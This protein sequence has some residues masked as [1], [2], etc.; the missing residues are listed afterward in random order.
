VLLGLPILASTEQVTGKVV[1]ISDGDTS[2]VLREEALW[3][4]LGVWLEKVKER[5]HH[6][7]RFVRMGRLCYV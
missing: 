5:R 6:H 4:L 3:N 1:G 2:S 7:G